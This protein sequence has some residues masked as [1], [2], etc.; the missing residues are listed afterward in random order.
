MSLGRIPLPNALPLF[1]ALMLLGVSCGPTG[2]PTHSR[3]A[4][5]SAVAARI[6]ER[7]AAAMAGDTAHWHRLVSDECVFTG[8]ALQLETTQ[9]VLGSIAA[10]RALRPAAQQVQDMVVFVHGDVA[11]ASYVQLVQDTGQAQTRGKR[12]RKTDV[13]VRRPTGWQLIGATEVDVPFRPLR[14]L[15]PREAARLVGEYALE[16]L[17]TLTV[18]AFSDGRLGLL[19]G[20]G[21]LDTLL[22]ASDSTAYM[23]GDAGTWVFSAGRNGAVAALRYQRPGARDVVLPRVGAK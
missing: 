18:L 19:G 13:F 2:A 5:S 22:A 8:P 3:T 6:H 14:A 17:D 11:Q 1:G 23:D 10:N 4:D 21:V 9:G 20:D 7:L 15:E 16:A 12:F